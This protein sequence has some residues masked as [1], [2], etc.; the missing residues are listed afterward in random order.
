[1]NDSQQILLPQTP[2]IQPLQSQKKGPH[3]EQVAQVWARI[4]TE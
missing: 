2:Y 4:Y 1:M 3:E